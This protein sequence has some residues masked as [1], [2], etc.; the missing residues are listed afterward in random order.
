MAPRDLFVRTLNEVVHKP[1]SYYDTRLALGSQLRERGTKFRPHKVDRTVRFR[2]QGPPN[3]TEAWLD[4]PLHC[5]SDSW[6]R[7]P[8]AARPSAWVDHIC[9]SE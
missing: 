2:Y 5:S 6:C 1:I 3:E 4:L 7:M 8:A 9:L